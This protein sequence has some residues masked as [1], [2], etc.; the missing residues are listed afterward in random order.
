MTSVQEEYKLGRGFRKSARSLIHD[1][2]KDTVHWLIVFLIRL[3]FQH[4]MW[5]YRLGYLLH[6]SIPESSDM[7][8]MDIGT[9]NA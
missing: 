9:G 6:P 5:L 7:R 8:V 2:D 4:W 1:Q 3:H